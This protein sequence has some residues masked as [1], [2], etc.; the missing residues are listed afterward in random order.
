VGP[1]VRFARRAGR[2]EVLERLQAAGLA[3]ER[4]DRH[5]VLGDRPQMDPGVAG[6]GRADQLVQW[7]LVGAGQRQQQLQGGAAAAGLQP[8]QRADRDAGGGRQLC[9]GHPAVLPQRPQPR[10]DGG[11]DVLGLHHTIC[12]YGNR[13]CQPRK[14]GAMVEA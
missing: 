6:G 2:D 1:H 4:H 14:V 7:D 9:K 13:V 3:G 5:A 10:S 11:E 8:G 12:R